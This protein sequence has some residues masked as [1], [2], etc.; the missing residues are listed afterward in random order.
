[1]PSEEKL[2]SSSVP[3][4][5]LK[6]E[7]DEVMACRG[8]ALTKRKKPRCVQDP[9]VMGVM[10]VRACVVG[11]PDSHLSRTY[12]SAGTRTLFLR[13]RGLR[14]EAC[15]P[16]EAF[17][18]DAA[19]A[20]RRLRMQI[21][22]IDAEILELV[23]RYCNRLSHDSAGSL[24]TFTTHTE[25]YPNKNMIRQLMKKRR[26][27]RVQVVGDKENPD[28]DRG[29]EAFKR[30]FRRVFLSAERSPDTPKAI[31]F[32]LHHPANMPTRYWETPDKSGRRPIS[33]NGAWQEARTRTFGREDPDVREHE[34]NEIWPA[35]PL[36]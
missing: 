34:G 36:T 23:S 14:S 18:G 33:D 28:A 3:R 4:Y 5:Q 13:P 26:S 7:R 17:G 9:R 2:E 15:L 8:L 21:I 24:T 35:C 1:M 27:S 29:R 6:E 22:S 31:L 32:R 10:D 25:L 11:W 19:T 20:L 12:H 16:A 30:F